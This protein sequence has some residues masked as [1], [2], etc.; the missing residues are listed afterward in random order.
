MLAQTSAAHELRAKRLRQE[1]ARLR[2]APLGT[3]P[4]CRVE[5]AFDDEYTRVNGCYV[6]ARCARVGVYEEVPASD[7]APGPAH[8]SARRAA[9]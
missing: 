6:H 1:L 9:G 4:A 7:G 2:S 8:V 5:V 3:C